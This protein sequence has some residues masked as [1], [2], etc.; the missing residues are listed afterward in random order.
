LCLSANHET[1]EK[2]SGLLDQLG[3]WVED[4]NLARDYEHK[5][6]DLVA[7]CK[8]SVA[9]FHLSHRDLAE[10]INSIMV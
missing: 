8:E 10:Q 6:V 2:L 1:T 3:I 7:A 9:S 4:S 5:R